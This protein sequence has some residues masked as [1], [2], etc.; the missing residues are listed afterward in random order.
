MSNLSPAFQQFLEENESNENN[1][2][3]KKNLMALH[4]A[5]RVFS[6]LYHPRVIINPCPEYK[7]FFRIYRGAAVIDAEGSVKTTDFLYFREPETF[8][9]DPEEM[10]AVFN[11]TKWN[12]E[13]NIFNEMIPLIQANN[14]FDSPIMDNSGVHLEMTV[15]EQV[16][17][18]EMLYA[19]MI[20]EQKV[21]FNLLVEGP[22][23]DHG[24]MGFR[25]FDKADHIKV[26][27]MLIEDMSE[28]KQELKKFLDVLDPGA[29]SIMNDIGVNTPTAYNWIIATDVKD[30]EER[31]IVRY[32][33]ATFL[34]FFP[35]CYS[36]ISRPYGKIHDLIMQGSPIDIDNIDII[37]V[38][39]EEMKVSPAVMTMIMNVNVPSIG[40]KTY[41]EEDQIIVIASRISKIPPD[42]MPTNP[43]DWGKL[44][45]CC[46]LIEAM[47]SHVP[48]EITMLMLSE[49]LTDLN[50][51]DEQK[52]RASARSFGTMVR[53]IHNNIS[54]AYSLLSGQNIP[55]SKAITML[56]GGDTLLDIS[57]SI[58]EWEEKYPEVMRQLL[59]ETRSSY[60]RKSY[61]WEPMSKHVYKTANGMTFR[62]AKGI[63]DLYEA[64]DL[65]EMPVSP[66]GPTFLKSNKQF[67]LINDSEGK[68]YGYVI[69]DIDKLSPMAEKG[70]KEN[71]PITTNPSFIIKSMCVANKEPDHRLNMAIWDFADALC[72]GT[73]R[74]NYPVLS[75]ELEARKITYGG[76]E[77]S[78]RIAPDYI[79]DVPNNINVAWNIIAPYCS[80]AVKNKSLEEVMG[81]DILLLEKRQSMLCAPMKQ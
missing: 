72:G 67:A 78:N 42:L 44:F 81:K 21:A 45:A 22:G 29:L 59:R 51:I 61:E 77:A 50:A 52:M 48:E 26:H 49:Q 11:E 7:A 79:A 68:P 33:R 23:F 19:I 25:S 4:K 64:D 41:L 53:F 65:L 55:Y 15:E 76:S 14:R 8:W 1:E 62:F 34:E 31:K 73:L 80:N 70:T 71:K 12:S 58:N 43:K 37:G 17:M 38:V 5:L 40:E 28:Y 3:A 47:S 20:D 74:V 63:A 39:S 32:N 18:F 16:K 66:F 75:S 57:N 9:S 60:N 6:R 24:C 35:L 56:V 13:A 2:N 36:I 10:K 27:D 46:E 69:I 30:E 54:S